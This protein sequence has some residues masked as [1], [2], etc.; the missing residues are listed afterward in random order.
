M[1]HMKNLKISGIFL[2]GTLRGI[3]L[4]IKSDLVRRVNPLASE[5]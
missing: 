4:V 1:M 5:A 3:F 2:R